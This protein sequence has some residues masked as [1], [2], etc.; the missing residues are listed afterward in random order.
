SGSSVEA[1][2]HRELERLGRLRAAQAAQAARAALASGWSR[3]AL[4]AVR[5]GLR[6]FPDDPELLAVLREIQ[7]SN[8][9]IERES[10][11][12]RAVLQRVR[13]AH[14]L[15]AQGKPAESL[16]VL[17]AVLRAEPDDPRAQ[18]AVQQVRQV[19]LAAKAGGAAPEP[20]SALAMR[21]AEARAAIAAAS[22][23]V[24]PARATS[25]RPS[26]PPRAM[27]RATPARATPAPGAISARAVAGRAVPGLNVQRPEGIPQEILLPRT[28]R[29]AT[30][31][32]LVLAGAAV[33]LAI[34]YFLVSSGAR[35]PRVNPTVPPPP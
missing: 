25:P 35:A 9:R 26:A 33:V 13:A 27:P 2:A 28:R 8:E 23:A 7:P 3:Q 20:P 17:R 21:A 18:A 14:E 29:R 22:A 15:L 34:V 4:A 30:P 16:K 10:S 5:R 24:K 1:E 31:P 6:A 11:R 19:V 12:R 32:V